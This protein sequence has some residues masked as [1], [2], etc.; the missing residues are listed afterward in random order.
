MLIYSAILMV[1]IGLGLMLC[2]TKH[3]K[4]LNSSLYCII[5]SIIIVSIIGLRSRSVGSDTEGYYNTYCSSN[6]TVS[7]LL[8]TYIGYLKRGVR[9]FFSE[10]NTT[11][12]RIICSIFHRAGFS[13]NAF[14]LVLAVIYVVPIAYLIHKDSKNEPM[15]FFWYYVFSLSLALSG[16]RMTVAIGLTTLAF[17]ELRKGSKLAGAVLFIISV[18]IHLSAFVF[19]VMFVIDRINLSNDTYK[20]L[21]PVLVLLPLINRF[22]AS[23]FIRYTYYDSTNVSNISWSFSLYSF[24]AVTTILL[25]RYKYNT[26]EIYCKAMIIGTIICGIINYGAFGNA[27]RYFTQYLCIVLPSLSDHFGDRYTQLFMNV[28]YVATGLYLLYR[29]FSVNSTYVPYH[30]LW[31]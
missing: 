10:K 4:K 13:F 16:V 11:V 25:T 17:I 20:K 26:D 6:D 3:G 19:V 22:V 21:I 2:N 23:A 7:D 18:M 29:T 31:Q 15:S 9:V 5:V 8:T 27:H 30:F 12:F 1:I 28:S 24:Y 14:L